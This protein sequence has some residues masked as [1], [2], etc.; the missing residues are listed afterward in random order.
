MIKKENF[1]VKINIKIA[2]RKHTFKGYTST[3]SVDIL[4]SF[5]PGMQ[6]KD[7]ES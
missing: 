1:L 3:Y 2:I 5:N 6:L 7:A 4:N